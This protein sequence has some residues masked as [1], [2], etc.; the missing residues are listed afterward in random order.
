MVFR[1]NLNASKPS[2]HPPHFSVGNRALSTHPNQFFWTVKT[3]KVT[4]IVPRSFAT[5]GSS[6]SSQLPAL[7]SR[8][9]A[10]SRRKLRSPHLLTR[11]SSLIS[12]IP[13]SRPIPLPTVR[14]WRSDPS[15]F[16]CGSHGSPRPVYSHRSP[17]L[18][19]TFSRV[20]QALMRLLQVAPSRC[21]GLF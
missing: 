18:P 21:Y 9:L 5:F 4:G 1:K 14:R 3:C 11:H 19:H 12:T 13:T 8:L 16:P 20:V 17:G 15:R 10:M 6:S 7:L 2:E